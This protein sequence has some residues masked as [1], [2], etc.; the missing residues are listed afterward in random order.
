M[1]RKVDDKFVIKKALES[2]QSQ[3][4]RFHLKDFNDD[5]RRV[6]Q[7][8]RF[9]KGQKT[10]G[11]T[12]N[13]KIVMNYFITIFNTFGDKAVDI[14]FEV[15]DEAIWPE[16]ITILMVMNKFPKNNKIHTSVGVKDLSTY[17]IS[18]DLLDVIRQE[19]RER[20]QR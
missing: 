8:S 10:A 4:R 17:N 9:L 5:V 15:A 7:L 18:F 19:M 11:V 12:M 2:Y 16:V 3:G 20:K 14:L 13:P 6:Y 1:A